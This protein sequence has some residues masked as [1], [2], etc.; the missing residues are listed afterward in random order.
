MSHYRNPADA[1]LYIRDYMRRRRAV[2]RPANHRS[3]EPSRVPQ[4]SSGQR[5]AALRRSS[6]LNLA[7]T[8]WDVVAL[9]RLS[10]GRHA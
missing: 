4:P 3:A 7:V 2:P 6:R 9:L 10:W 5:L 8:S 1:R